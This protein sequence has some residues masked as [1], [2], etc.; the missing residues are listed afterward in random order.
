MR[1]SL[2]AM[3][4]VDSPDASGERL[5]DLIAKARHPASPEVAFE[6]LDPHDRRDLQK[7][8]I[9]FARRFGG[10]RVRERFADYPEVPAELLG[11]VRKG[12]F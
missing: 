8:A 4:G 3:H 1:K 11:T 6:P 5:Y 9:G 7:I 10:R 12:R 2:R